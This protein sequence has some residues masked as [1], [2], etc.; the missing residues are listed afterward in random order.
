MGKSKSSKRWL[1]EHHADPYVLQS[2]REGYRSRAVYKLIEL[3]EKDHLLKPGQFVVD[4]GAAPGGWTE[5][6]SQFCSKGGRLIAVDLLEMD[7]ITDVDIIQGDFTEQKVLDEILQLINNS[8]VDLVLSDMA[9]NIS[10]IE[11]VDQPKSMYL[12]ELAFEFCLQVLDKNGSFAVK[13]F[14][15]EGFDEMVRSFRKSFKVVKFRKPKA[16]RARSRE[17]YAVCQGLK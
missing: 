8:P 7:S 10:G 11:T 2:R 1:Q 13:M 12:V 9:P 17:V 14:Q 3:Q 4:L 16:S 15:G 5:Y 6:A